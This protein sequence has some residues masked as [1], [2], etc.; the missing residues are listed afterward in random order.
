MWMWAPSPM[1]PPPSMWKYSEATD[2]QSSEPVPLASR[3]NS[4]AKL[5]YQFGVDPQQRAAQRL[6]AR[7]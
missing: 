6:R 3:A 7:R 1:C 4:G 2:W 5:D